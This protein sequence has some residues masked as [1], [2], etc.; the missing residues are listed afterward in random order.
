M[1]AVDELLASACAATGLDD[2][3]DPSWQEGLEVL[4]ASA[5]DDA[6]LTAMGEAIIAAQIGSSLTNRLRVVDWHRTHPEAADAPV[7]RPVFILGLPRTGTTLLSY[8]LDADPRNRSLLRWEAFA[9]VPPPDPAAV[10]SDPRVATARAEMDALYA[11]APA[12]KAIHY[13]AADGPTECVTLLGQD[14]RSVHYETLA[15]LPTYGE[16]HQSCDMEPAYRWHRRVLQTL[17]YAWPGRWV[18]KSPCHN[19]ALDALDAVYPDARFVCTHRDPT[20]VVASLCSLVSVLSGLGTDHDFNAYIG[21]RWLDLTVAMIDRFLDF[22]DRVGEA[23]FHDV[24]YRALA[25]DPLAAAA[26][27]YGWL[28]WPFDDAAR[29]AMEAYVAANPRGRFGTHEYSLDPFGLTATQVSERFV[30]YRA[31]FGLG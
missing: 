31:R 1:L 21:R 30:P 5:N 20:E 11:A 19:L 18:L 23:R 17:Q 13:E 16:W 7:D 28:G 22:R 2:L 9:A 12:F 14:F 4:V 29:T 6:R 3:G 24:D 15:N 8:L 26:G 25:A 27:L 10:G